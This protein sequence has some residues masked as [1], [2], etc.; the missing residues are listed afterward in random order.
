L[1]AAAYLAASILS[2]GLAKLSGRSF[3]SRKRGDWITAIN[4]GC[5]CGARR[6]E[7][8]VEDV[9][10]VYAY[11]RHICQRWT[12]SAFSVQALAAEDRLDVTRP[13]V[14]QEISTGDRTSVS[15]SAAS[16]THASTIRTRCGPG[17]L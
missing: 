4:D 7:I 15:E 14:V 11:H 10:R 3:G 16:A 1:L 9:P 6:Y 5:R 12:G 17:L 2:L 8:A 13:I